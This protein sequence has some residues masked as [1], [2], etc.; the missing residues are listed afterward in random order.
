[1]TIKAKEGDETPSLSEDS[2][3]QSKKS[4]SKNEKLVTFKGL[5][6][7]SIIG[8]CPINMVPFYKLC[9]DNDEV[10]TLIIAEDW[11]PGDLRFSVHCTLVQ[12][13]YE[14]DMSSYK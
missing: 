4:K 6:Q 9:P 5:F 8:A 14:S 3:Q 7:V 12:F 1:M 11:V 13:L 10:D 2:D